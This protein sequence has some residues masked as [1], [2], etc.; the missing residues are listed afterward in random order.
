MNVSVIFMVFILTAFQVS[1][2]L[3]WHWFPQSSQTDTLRVEVYQQKKVLFAASIPICAMDRSNIEPEHPQKI[4]QFSFE[5]ECGIFGSEFKLLGVRHIEGNIW[6]AGSDPDD[7]LLGV[8]FASE[9]QVFLNTVHIA[10]AKKA[11]KTNLA[12]GLYIKS[13]PLHLKKPALKHHKRKIIL[14]IE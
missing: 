12:Q 8:S 14:P 2:D 3:V 7:V 13:Y 1:Q 4:L 10:L 6:E 5:A 9:E 11:A